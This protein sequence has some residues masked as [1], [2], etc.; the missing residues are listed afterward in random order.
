L[1]GPTLQV[2]V[3]D[4]S[5]KVNKGL[6]EA[7]ID[8]LN[9]EISKIKEPKKYFTKILDE[10]SFE[11][12]DKWYDTSILNAEYGKI[13]NG[14]DI[15]KLIDN[16]ELDKI[17][18]KVKT[19]IIGKFTSWGINTKIATWIFDAIKKNGFKVTR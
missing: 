9:S 14:T 18:E 11:L 5:Q 1:Q 4:D 19:S 3:T 12:N 15:T 13:N 2:W 8:R 7:E 10:I 6:I 17:F 16:W